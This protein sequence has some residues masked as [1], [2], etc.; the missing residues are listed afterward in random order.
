M[1][2]ARRGD[3]TWGARGSGETP[4]PKLPPP[5]NPPGSPHLS[6]EERELRA[7]RGASEPCSRGHTGG[8]GFVPGGAP[9]IEGA[10][11]PRP[12]PRAPPGGRSSAASVLQ[13]CLPAGGASSTRRS[14]RRSLIPPSPM[15]NGGAAPRPFRFVRSVDC[16]TQRAPRG[17]GAGIGVTCGAAEPRGA[18]SFGL[19]S[20]VLRRAVGWGPP[21]AFC[22][23]GLRAVGP[24]HPQGGTWRGPAS[25]AQPRWGAQGCG[26]RGWSVS[27]P[28]WGCPFVCASIR[29]APL[30]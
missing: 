4:T 16:V 8:G 5:P 15:G 7:L 21:S 6:P 23:P 29:A 1:I 25:S 30:E 13:Q 18:E 3:P 12:E 2:G 19:T 11:P 20:V 28:S 14:A 26:V 27:E 9:C 10:P 24:P 17:E 22:A